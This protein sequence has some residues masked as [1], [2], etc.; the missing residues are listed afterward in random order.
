MVKIGDMITM[1]D[2]YS[3]TDVDV[4]VIYVIDDETVVVIDDR[5]V[6]FKAVYDEVDDYWSL[7]D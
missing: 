5:D 7:L 6:P 3:M 2:S 4:K 1:V